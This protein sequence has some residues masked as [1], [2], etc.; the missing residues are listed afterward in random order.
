M[1]AKAAS[2]TLSGRR[3]A[4]SSSLIGESEFGGGEITH[5][6]LKSIGELCRRA[7]ESPL[8]AY[9]GRPAAEMRLA[10]ND[11]MGGLSVRLLYVTGTHCSLSPSHQGISSCHNS[12][13]CSP[14]RSMSLP[15]C[16]SVAELCLSTLRRAGVHTGDKSFPWVVYRSSAGHRVFRLVSN[17]TLSN[18]KICLRDKK[19]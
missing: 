2:A 8:A 4:P 17:G 7:E 11:K 16:T 19:N 9:P 12:K 5:T 3:V 6:H 15:I 18:S 1:F 13:R 14:T 10:A